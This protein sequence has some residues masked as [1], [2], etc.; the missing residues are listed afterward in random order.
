MN[1]IKTNQNKKNF[2]LEDEVLGMAAEDNNVLINSE[3]NKK[4]SST[5]DLYD[6]LALEA[7]AWNR[8][9]NM[10]G[11]STGINYKLKYPIQLH[12]RKQ[13]RDAMT[14]IINSEFEGDYS[15]ATPAKYAKDRAAV[16]RKL[17]RDWKGLADNC[18]FEPT[19]DIIEALNEIWCDKYC[20]RYNLPR[21]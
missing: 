6:A 8:W 9:I 16:I 2:I 1:A 7:H 20:A 18:F 12:I 13:F 11:S 4:N 3:Q 14:D 21:A 17:K 19:A 10:G 5:D 15:Y